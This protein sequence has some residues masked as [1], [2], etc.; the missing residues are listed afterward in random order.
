LSHRLIEAAVIKGTTVTTPALV[1]TQ[2]PVEIRSLLAFDA[3]EQPCEALT[4]SDRQHEGIEDDSKAKRPGP[5]QTRSGKAMASVL[6]DRAESPGRWSASRS[7][8]VV[9]LFAHEPCRESG[10]HLTGR[11]VPAHVLDLAPTS[12]L[13]PLRQRHAHP[14]AS[15]TM[16]DE[17]HRFANNIFRTVVGFR[18]ATH[19]TRER[20]SDARS[21]SSLPAT[22]AFSSPSGVKGLPR[23]CD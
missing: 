11:K 21:S 16:S 8:H 15:T 22:V 19:S 4:R 12:L 23:A 3:V 10:R 20:R 6:L 14:D 1:S 2:R 7:S 5:G 9:Y 18:I 13:Q 17:V